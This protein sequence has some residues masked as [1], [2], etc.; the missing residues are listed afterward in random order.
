MA[1]KSEMKNKVKVYQQVNVMN[2]KT[3][4]VSQ[5]WLYQFTLWCRV[6][7][8][9][10]EQLEAITN[11]VQTYRKRL[12]METT[13][14]RTSAQ[15]NS[16]HRIVYK[17]EQYTVSIVGDTTGASKRLRFLAERLEDGGA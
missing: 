5:Q 4:E 17:G 15:L 2:K 6:K 7:P 10:R 16:T 14:T 3:G 8:I 12:E 9:F 13:Y 11:G 1:R